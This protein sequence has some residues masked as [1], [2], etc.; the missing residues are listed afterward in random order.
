M[1]SDYI[2]AIEQ[3]F[4]LGDG[5]RNFPCEVPLCKEKRT[6]ETGAGNVCKKHALMLVDKTVDN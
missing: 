4:D 2:K 1:K 6:I 3:T 5:V